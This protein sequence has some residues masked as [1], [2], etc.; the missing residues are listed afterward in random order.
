M[1]VEA[2]AT[3]SDAAMLF[4]VEPDYGRA[5]LRAAV[6]RKLLKGGKLDGEA[7]VKI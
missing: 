5:C 1:T 6:S 2:A 4:A 7:I 3:T